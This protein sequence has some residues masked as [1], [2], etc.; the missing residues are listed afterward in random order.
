[1]LFERNARF[2]TVGIALASFGALLIALLWY[3]TVDH[4]RGEL[5]EAKQS[6]FHKN[7]KLALALEVQ[8]TRLL[9]A[10]D[11]LLTILA[12]HYEREDQP[13][14]VDRLVPPDVAR[15]AGFVLIAHIDAAGNLVSASPTFT[16]VS[17]ADRLH[18]RTHRAQNTG[19]L[20]ITGP[21]MGRIT[22]QPI[23]QLTRR[24]NNPDGTFGGVV[25]LAVEPGYFTEIFQSAGAAP[26]DVMSLVRTDGLTLARRV[27]ARTTFGE[28][29]AGSALLANHARNPVGNYLGRGALDGVLKFFSYRTLPDQPLIAT[30]GTNADVVLAP[31]RERRR[32]HYILAAIATGFITFFCAGLSALIRRGQFAERER[33]RMADS[34][35]YT[36]QQQEQRYRAIFEGVT[37]GIVIVGRDSRIV[38]ANR[39]AEV[40]HGWAEGA[41]VGRDAAELIDPAE[42]GVLH[43]VESEAAW[44]GPHS[45]EARSM[46]RDG[47]RLD[48][49]LSSSRV[50]I[51]GE[52]NLLLVITNVSKEK[53]LQHQLEH[54]ARVASL[55]RIAA[56]IAHEMNNV[57]MG[58]MPFAEILTRSGST[59]PQVA[60]AA[61]QIMRSVERGRAATQGILR[62]TR[63]VNE[64]A[65]EAFAAAPFLTALANELRESMPPQVAFDV[66]CEEDLHLSGDASQL[67]QVVTN[68]VS[69][70]REAMPSGGMLTVRLETLDSVHAARFAVHPAKVDEWAH[71]AVRDTG[72]GIAP[73][74]FERI[75]EPLFTTKREAGSGL[76]LPI[77]KQIVSAHGGRIDV[78]NIPG[79][80]AVFHVLLVKAVPHS[81]GCVKIES[82]N[83]WS[84]ISRVLLVDDEPV[85]GDGITR[86]LRIE[87]IA[88]EWIDRGQAAVERLQE[89]RP[90]LLILDVGLPDMN[91]AEV[92]ERASAR[93]PGLLTIFST[94]HGDQRI[95]DALSAPPNVKVLSKPWDF[96]MLTACL[97]SL[98]HDTEDITDGH[99]Q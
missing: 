21:L 1:M 44:G 93:H 69:N 84:K 38:A 85:I 57:L 12:N 47:E 27:G 97:A 82:A 29:I 96:E 37:N 79:G 66:S 11:D 91:G 80:G 77:V 58:I 52:P 8:T 30:V 36:M 81:T 23:V 64:P 68:L 99:T 75:F 54:S 92:Y 24:I 88:C 90:D 13:F 63:A 86:L 5:A 26:G 39:A 78:E 60:K 61:A 94:G 40:M 10:A 17:V 31:V 25:L 98:L 71:L 50:E 87:G 4:T 83:P 65:M 62:F 28:S 89:F 16:S 74:A 9:R 2:P 95:V 45:W 7:E 20:L 53:S 33:S 67:Q 51:G 3:Y 41:L 46:R 49:L 56:S 72:T 6:E 76:G 48:V 32:N 18:F 14:P 70:A 55:G 73:E 59:D 43:I 35:L 42:A 15:R 22:G 19:K 34:L